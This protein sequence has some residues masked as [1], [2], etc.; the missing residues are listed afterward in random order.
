MW[1]SVELI[2]GPVQRRETKSGMGK[3]LN[4]VVKASLERMETEKNEDEG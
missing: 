2:K 4:L 3:E 1:S